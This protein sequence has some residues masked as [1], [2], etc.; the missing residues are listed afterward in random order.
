MK[1][2][3]TCN[4]NHIKLVEAGVRALLEAVSPEKVRTC[5]A[6]QMNRINKNNKGQRW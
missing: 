1:E 6:Q 5:Q 4:G 2:L 3:N